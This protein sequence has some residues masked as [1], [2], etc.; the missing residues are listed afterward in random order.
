MNAHGRRFQA[1]VGLMELCGLTNPDG[2][3]KFGRNR[4]VTIRE[5]ITTHKQQDHPM[6]LGVTRKWQSSSWFG[7]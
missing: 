1:S 3:I 6:F 2:I 7:V 5:L 4:S